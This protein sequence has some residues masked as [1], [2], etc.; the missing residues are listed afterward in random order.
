MS[1]RRM[2]HL[3]G[4]LLL[5]SCS[6]ESTH[7]AGLGRLPLGPQTS[8]D[9]PLF[10]HFPVLDHRIVQVDPATGKA[11]RIFY[12]D[13]WDP[14]M[15]FVQDFAVR[16]TTLFALLG[17]RRLQRN[18]RL[19]IV[20]P[21]TG[22]LSTTLALPPEPQSV[23]WTCDGQ[24]LVAHGTPITGPPGQLTVVSVD[25]PGVKKTIALQGACLSVAPAGS[26]VLVLERTLREM[27]DDPLVLF[28]LAELDLAGGKVLRRKNLPPG[29]R[30]VVVGPSGLIYV[31]HTS[32]QG[33]MGTDGTISVLDPRS[34]HLV[35]RLQ[36]DMLVK[37]MLPTS[38]HLILTMLSDSGDAWI[39]VQSTTDLTEMDVR[40]GE[41][42]IPQM[43]VVGSQL[44]VPLKRGASLFRFDLGS[45]KRLPGL[46]LSSIKIKDD[47]P[48]LVRSWRECRAR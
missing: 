15:D 24:L 31:S 16:R 2:I 8:A 40:L 13:Q 23:T 41:L 35:R 46:K 29:A 1:W 19:H 21:K 18:P 28:S 48:G 25:P 27:K 10:V 6:Q 47:R 38:K 37:Q 11:A 39:S 4:L 7:L 36:L 44:L 43:Q 26:R 20:D 5:I 9:S 32:G 42:I 14:H 45:G 33:I 17:T 22:E 30:Q 12:P 3:G 34:L